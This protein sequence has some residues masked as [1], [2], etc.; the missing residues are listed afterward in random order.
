MI[1]QWPLTA[2]KSLNP[3]HDLQGPMWPAPWHLLQP[4]W[5]YP[6]RCH[7]CLLVSSHRGLLVVT[8]HSCLP[9]SLLCPM[10]RMLFPPCLHGFLLHFILALFK[11]HII[12]KAF[13]D[14]P[15]QNSILPPSFIYQV[16]VRISANRAR[17]GDREISDGGYIFTY[18]KIH[19]KI[20]IYIFYHLSSSQ[21]YRYH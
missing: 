16:T 12:A 10:S 21:E 9:L 2:L 18:I 14:Y 5:S 20:H 8:T 6:L 4:L 3:Y 1:L 17:E 19:I 7:C 13:Y 15:I 11:C